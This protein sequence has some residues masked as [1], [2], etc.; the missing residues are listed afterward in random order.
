MDILT[1]PWVIIPLIMI[2]LIGNMAAFKYLTPKNLDAY[3]KKESD[4]D[5]L[6][7]LDKK[8]RKALNDEETENKKKDTEH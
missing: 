2:I 5:R 4:L 3:K 1:S 7:E 8:R 6:I